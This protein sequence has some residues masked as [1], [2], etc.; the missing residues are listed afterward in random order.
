MRAHTKGKHGM[1]KRFA[2]LVAVAA[3]GVMA[4]G[5]Q[6]VM[7]LGAQTAAAG[8]PTSSS[9]GRRSRTPSSPRVAVTSRPGHSYVV[10]AIEAIA[11]F[12][13]W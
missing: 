13:S 1:G 12:G 9:R 10:P 3:A 2:I 4:F 8:G 6:T 7:A 11:P 5:A